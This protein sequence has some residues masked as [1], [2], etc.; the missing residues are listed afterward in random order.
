[1]HNPDDIY[2][3][4]ELQRVQVFKK[5]SRSIDKVVFELPNGS[6]D[7]FYIKVEGPASGVL[8]L[9]RDNKI[10][11]V[12]QFRPGPKEILLELPGGFIGPG[13]E[14]LDTAKREFTEETG[15][16]GEMEY[17]G[18]CIDDAYS[19]MRRYYFVARNC[20]KVGEPQQTPTEKTKVV[21]LSINEFRDLLRSGKLTDI[22]IGYLCL[23]YL[24]LL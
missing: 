12:Q 3:W 11:L 7:E 1:M 4:K 21:L 15:Y 16:T 14:Q 13:E 20:V 5:Y 18:N 19:T 22:E 23:D 9:T 24:K 17:V 8:G 6:R 2:A 10:I